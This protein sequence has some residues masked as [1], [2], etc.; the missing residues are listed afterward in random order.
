MNRRVNGGVLANEHYRE[1]VREL[2]AH[3]TLSQRTDT[4]RLSVPPEAR[5]WATELSK[6][7]VETLAAR[8]YDVVGSLDELIPQGAPEDFTDPDLPSHDEVALDATVTLLREAARL[9]SENDRLTRE[10]DDARR[11]LEAGVGPGGRFKR[12]VVRASETRPALRRMLSIYRK[13]RGR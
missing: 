10:L 5:T 7:W 11:E 4:P 2:L 13:A 6:Q 9:R 8:G 12:R 1:F 3:R